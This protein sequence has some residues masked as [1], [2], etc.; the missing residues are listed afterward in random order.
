MQYFSKLFENIDDD[1][2]DTE[3]LEDD[4]EIIQITGEVKKGLKG[5]KNWKPGGGDDVCMQ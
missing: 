4:S 1:S 3:L 5:L 2:V